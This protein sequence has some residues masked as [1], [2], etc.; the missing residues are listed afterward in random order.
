MHHQ[1]LILQVLLLK[2]KLLRHLFS[3]GRHLL[4]QGLVLVIR[5][6]GC[7]STCDYIHWSLGEV[8][9]HVR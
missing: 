2:V 6:V 4:Q 9:L 3:N 1:K 8:R 5:A 7:E